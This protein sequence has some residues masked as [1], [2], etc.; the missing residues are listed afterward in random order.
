[1]GGGGRPSSV[2]L[3]LCAANRDGIASTKI[4]QQQNYSTSAQPDRFRT[5]E[6]DL[7]PQACQV[8]ARC[9]LSSGRRRLSSSSSRG[10]RCQ[11]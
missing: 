8:E 9:R 3:G 11:L 2:L 1:M 6:L 7:R 5:L 4:R 10:I